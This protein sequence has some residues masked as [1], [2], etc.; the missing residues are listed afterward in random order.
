M[1]LW[2]LVFLV[3]TGSVSE[4]VRAGCGCVIKFGA[5]FLG[6]AWGYLHWW[7]QG[8]SWKTSRMQWTLIQRCNQRFET[9]D[10]KLRSLPRD[11]LLLD[12]RSLPWSTKTRCSS[13]HDLSTVAARQLWTLASWLALSLFLRKKVELLGNFSVGLCCP[14]SVALWSHVPLESAS[15]LWFFCILVQ[16]WVQGAATII[17]YSFILSM[18]CHTTW[19]TMV[20]HT[21]QHVVQEYLVILSGHSKLQHCELNYYSCWSLFLVQ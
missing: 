18:T 1:I 2:W 13:K 12:L 6:V 7:V 9:W 17:V 3:Y 19:S 15:V 20:L 10:L 8:Q 11:S 4:L 16:N 14:F 5:L 21:I